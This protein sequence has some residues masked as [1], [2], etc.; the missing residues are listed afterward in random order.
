[1]FSRKGFGNLESLINIK[2]GRAWRENLNLFEFK[3]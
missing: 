1:M 2:S 3:N